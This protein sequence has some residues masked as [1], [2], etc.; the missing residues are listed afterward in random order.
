MSNLPTL[1]ELHYNVQEAFK[2]DQ[3]NTLLNQPPH[4][5]WL[6]EYPAV[7]GIKGEY[8]PIDKIDFM[9]TRIFQQWHPEVISYSVLFQSI[10]V[11]VRL[12]YKNPVTGEWSF[13]DGVGACPVQVDAGKNASDL[14]AIKSRAVQMALPIAKTNAVKDAAEELGALFGRDLNRKDTVLFSGSYG[15]QPITGK[16]QPV[17]VQHTQEMIHEANSKTYVP[18]QRPAEL[19]PLNNTINN[20]SNAFNPS[21][22]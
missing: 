2:N 22:L 17:P 4:K 15:E 1:A 13:K 7:M 20:F 19:Q 18:A 5:D 10:A 3:L 9:L 14:G 12:H 8:L 16:P 21:D 11:H 6:K